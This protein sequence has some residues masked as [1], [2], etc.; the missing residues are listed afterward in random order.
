MGQ[1]GEQFALLLKTPPFF[2]KHDSM[3]RTLMNPPRAIVELVLNVLT[4]LICI[5]GVN[6]LAS[7]STALSVSIVLNLRKFLS[8][9]LSFCVFGHRIDPGIVCGAILVLLGGMCSC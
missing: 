9:V 5:I 4:Q 1:V 3:G 7:K 2:N 8:L 6:R